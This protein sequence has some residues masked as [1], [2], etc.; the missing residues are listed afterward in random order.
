MTKIDDGGPAFPVEVSHHDDGTI[1]GIQTG[2]TT[3][4]CPGMSIADYFAQG[5]LK[6]ILDQSYWPLTDESL[7]LA[8]ATA[9][10]IAYA[11]L[12]ERKHWT[13]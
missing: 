3:G 11:M 9:Y 2:N 4:M 10:R 7:A 6:I 5:A 1:H 13:P 8:A 12:K